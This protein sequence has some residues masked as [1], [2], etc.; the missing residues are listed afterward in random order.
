[1]GEEGTREEETKAGKETLHPL[2]FP[3]VLTHPAILSRVILTTGRRRRLFHLRLFP[4]Q[5]LLRLFPLPLVWEEKR[6]LPIISVLPGRKTT[7]IIIRKRIRFPRLSTRIRSRICYR[8]PRPHRR[9]C[10]SIREILLELQR[11]ITNMRYTV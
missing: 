2:I 1:M 8:L 5:I 10:R 9:G 11:F 4:Q 6:A 7:T 3:L